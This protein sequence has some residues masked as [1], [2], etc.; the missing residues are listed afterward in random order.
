MR[1]STITPA[2]ITLDEAFRSRELLGAALGDLRSWRTW[3]AAL[4]AAHGE[5]L[6][7][8]ELK[9]FE[10]VAG[11]RKPPTR[12]VRRFV[13]AISR[14]A[15]KGRM[16]GA[17]AVYA[18]AICKHA[19]APGEVGV[20]AV[21]SPTRDQS[22]VVFR[23][24]LAFLEAS[25]ILRGM[26]ADKTADEIRLSNGNVI[27]TLTADYRS[28]RGRTLL[29]AI[30]DEASFLRDETSSTPD[31]EAARALL[32]GLMTT[33][34]MLCVISSPY[35]KKGLLHD[36]HKD[37]F[38]RDSNDTLVVEG[39][40]T[41]FNPTLDADAVAAAVALDP[42]GG[43]GEWLGLF[44]SDRAAFLDDRTIDRAVDRDRRGLELAPFQAPPI[45]LS[46][47]VA[48]AAMTR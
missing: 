21:I 41:V 40:S 1:Q 12:K 7:T 36:L 5:A 19:L 11:G 35:R 10:R 6:G 38:G 25:P 4:K 42:E 8:S 48:R 22:E 45:S 32:P 14:R 17:L 24:A 23:Y 29:L 33:R 16:M 46:S 43:R 34:G 31:I 15:G 28:V 39:P 26:V 3:R 13:A 30:L 2:P 47:T 20:V 37:F 44:R 18:A 27:K 9:A